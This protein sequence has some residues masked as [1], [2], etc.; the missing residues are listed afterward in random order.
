MSQPAANPQA[1]LRRLLSMVLELHRMGYSQIAYPSYVVLRT[2]LAIDRALADLKETVYG[3]SP[4][5][6]WPVRRR[7]SW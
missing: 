3:K 5:A 4:S 6:A 7:R 1:V 2:A